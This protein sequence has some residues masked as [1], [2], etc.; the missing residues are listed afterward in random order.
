MNTLTFKDGQTYICTKSD[1]PWWTEGKEYHV[2]LN[3]ENQPVIPDD[4]GDNWNSKELNGPN[5]YFKLKD[6]LITYTQLEVQQA[7]IKAYQMYDN[8]AQRLA[9]IKGYFAK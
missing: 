1:R 3:T 4:Q 7:I 2:V 5:S 9:F 6:E 8:D